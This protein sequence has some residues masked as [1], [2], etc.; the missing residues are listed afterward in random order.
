MK[1]LI[2]MLS[3]SLLISCNGKNEQ[4]KM[5]SE[6][7]TE[8]DIQ[9][10]LKSIEETR[11]AFQLAIKENRFGDLRQYGTEDV[12]SLTPD[13]GVWEPFKRLSE[14]PVGKFHYD[15]L[16]MHPKETIIVSDSIAYDFGTSSTYYTNEEG[17]AIELTATFLAIL[18]KD[19]KDGKWKLHREVANTRDLD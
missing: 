6:E 14:N 12:K 3:M 16:V 5:K 9:A 18:K 17:E 2:I 7:K 10:E 1:N 4:S 11:N 13:C 19:K 8:L 15:S